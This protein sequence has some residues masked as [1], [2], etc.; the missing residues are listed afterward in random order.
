MTSSPALES[1]AAA[2]A[3]A[4]GLLALAALGFA[5]GDLL[6]QWQPAPRAASWRGLAALVSSTVLAVVG[7]GLLVPR[8]RRVAAGIG[9]AWI[10]VW[11]V[12][13]HV[14]AT[15]AAKGQV[16]AILGIAECSAMALGLASLVLPRQRRVLIA[17]FGLCCMIFGLSHAVYADFTAKMVPSWVPMPLA[18]AWLTGAVHAIAGLCLVIGI[19]M[20]FAAAIEA[21]MMTS[22]VLLLH[23]PHVLAAP[24]NRLELTMLA[25]AWTLT[26]AAWLIAV[27]TR[28]DTARIGA[29]E[30]S[31]R[32][33]AAA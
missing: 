22:F 31:M 16:G 15:I 23:L 26:S 17:L 12:A 27:A 19:A 1:T 9:A 30:A 3:I 11:V 4:I 29:F 13:L 32:S 20:P 28:T 6:L 18:V 24:T 8:S 5:Y 25:I 14:P 33:R 21:A 10:A 2:V 7:I